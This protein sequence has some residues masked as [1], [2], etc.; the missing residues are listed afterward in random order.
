MMNV[1]PLPKGKVDQVIVAQLEKLL[2]EAKDG[3]L[4]QVV[5]VGF[6]RD[7]TV[8]QYVSLGGYLYEMI[9]ELKVVADRISQA[10]RE[11]SQDSIIN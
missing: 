9:G 5:Y 3:N 10:I 6:L 7:E 11:D 4:H 2:N 1:I 8:M